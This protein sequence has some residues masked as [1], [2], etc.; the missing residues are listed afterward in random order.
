MTRAQT[1]TFSTLASHTGGPG[2]ADGTGN[3]ASIGTLSSIAV[4][5]IGNAY[6]LDTYYSPGSIRKVTPAGVVTTAQLLSS[7]TFNKPVSLAVDA[8]GNFYI[9]DRGTTTIIKLAPNGTTTTLAGKAYQFGCVDGTGSAARFSD[10][11]AL[12]ID[13]AGN[14]YVS[15]GALALPGG[16][17]AIRK[18]TPAG[19][20]TTLAGNPGVQGNVDGT[21]SAAEFNDP[22]GIAVDASGNV[23][24]ADGSADLIRRVTPAGVV[25]TLAGTAYHTG[26]D[27]GAGSAAR[28]HSPLDVAVDAA[29]NVYVADA[30]NN[31]IRRMTPDGVVTTLAGSAAEAG[32]VD[33]A[34]AAAR[35]Y[36]P[37]AL[38][39][40]ASGAVWIADRGNY[41]VR[42]MSSDG[43]VTT[44]AGAP[45]SNGY[46]DGTGSAARFDHPM[47]VA[48]DAA[49][50]LYVGEATNS[51]VRRVTPAGVVTTYVGK[52]F[53]NSAG[54]S[55]QLIFPEGVAVD[56][57]GTLY[58]A[59]TDRNRIYKVP[60]GA[61]PLFVAGS[62]QHGATD[63]QGVAAGFDSP[64]GIAVDAAGNVFVADTGNQAIRKVTPDGTVT[65]FAGT[66]GA[67]GNADGTGA[68]ARFSSPKGLA[69]DAAGNL[70]V[71]DLFN[72]AI[73]KITPTGVVTTIAGGTFGVA[74]GTGSAAGFE[75]PQ[76]VAVDAAGNLFVADTGAGTIRKITPGGVVTTIGGTP[77]ILGGADGIG[78]AAAFNAPVAIAVDA[79]GN[80][81]IADGNF[82]VFASGIG[83]NAIRKGVPSAA[84]TPAFTTQPQSQSTAAGSSLTCSAAASDGAGLQWQRNGSD[85][86]G[87]VSPALMLTD[88]Q[89]ADTGLYA[90]IATNA[91][92]TAA[93][94]FAIVGVT[95]TARAIGA[96][97][98]VGTDIVH[99]NG[100]HFAQVLATGAAEAI[101]AGAGKVT[102]TSFIDQN[103]DI[104]Q[105]EFSGAG[106]LSLVLDDATGPATPTNYNQPGTSYMKGNA[107]IVIAGADETTN[108]AVFTVGRAT[109]FDP[110]GGY[111]IL[112]AP[113]GTNLPANNGSPLFMGHA[114]MAYDGVADIAF[115]AIESTDGKFGG[116]RTSN[117]RYSAAKGLTGVYAPGVAFQGPVYIGNIDGFGTATAAIEVG[118]VMDARITGGDLAQDNGRPV[119]VSGLT[120]LEFTAGSDSGGNVLPAKTNRAMLEQ[121][122]M[123]VTAQL[124]GGP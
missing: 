45:L 107:G 73:R 57:T 51:D 6:F 24:V 12:A 37:Y 2:N 29:G 47:G 49:G 71:T 23:Y 103:D 111:N 87:A 26:S 84:V 38:A 124:V 43:T 81:Y 27:D 109:A 30:N 104:V 110:T 89:P 68:A 5:A 53:T 40:D 91:G 13:A 117:A 114:M 69:I 16:S 36:Y 97:M 50:N 101:T 80:L 52:N 116:L 66:L 118:S 61:S 120:H 82:S 99:P 3:G 79:A 102:R 46:V 123:D 10:P 25:T 58:I 63:G 78:P 31:E 15:D 17:L 76:G 4:D 74:D 67:G 70:Y 92:G 35:F 98:V 19:V 32:S 88:V 9:G 7:D 54:G 95:A 64:V 21:G 14:L 94:S 55:D 56:A 33:G 22:E 65:T 113:G 90:A 59:D 41:Q 44:M 34:G 62:G 115:I 60:P 85:V 121:D 83:N 75:F 105:V 119:Q 42:R 77:G 11:R 18:I 72:Q 122:G 20:V 48:L 8:A 39:V 86:A 1:Y 100:N 93:S 96:A 106:T 28:F 108:V 112:M